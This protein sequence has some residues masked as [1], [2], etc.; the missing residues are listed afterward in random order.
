MLFLMLWQF[1][2]LIAQTPPVV[3]NSYRDS[4]IDAEE[5]TELI[6]LQDNTDLRGFTIRDN[7]TAGNWQPFVRFRNIDFWNHMR[8]GTIIVLFHRNPAPGSAFANQLNTGKSD[9]HIA[10]S[11]ENTEYFEYEEGGGS[12]PLASMSLAINGDMIQ[13]RNASGAHVHA[14]GHRADTTTNFNYWSALPKPKL[15]HRANLT[16]SNKEA[17]M[18]VPGANLDQYGFLSPINGLTYTQKGT[19]NL[20]GFPNQGTSGPNASF[21]RSLRQPDWINPTL[22]ASYN[23]QNHQVNLSW[24]SL[25]DSYPTDN[26]HGYMVLRS[27]TNSFQA[28]Q[29]GVIHGVGSQV[30]SATVVAL[31]NGSQNT[32]FT[33]N[34]SGNPIPCGGQYYYRV[35]AFRYGP[36]E[37]D[38]GSGPTRGR[39][40]NE[41]AFA[42]A[43]AAN[44]VPDASISIT[45]SSYNI[46]PG[47]QV[48][49]TASLINPGNNPTIT[50]YV[51]G[52]Q[53]QSGSSLTFS[54]TFTATAT[55]TATLQSS[56]PCAAPASAPP[57]QITVTAN[58]CN[59]GTILG[60]D[61]ICLNQ[62]ATY[63]SNG[64]TGGIWSVSNASIAQVNSQGVVTPLQPGTFTLYYTVD[65]SSCTGNPVASK[66]IFINPLP[67][68]GPDR[69]ICNTL[70][71]TLQGNAPIAGQ[72]F[73]SQVDGASIAVFSDNTYPNS[74]VTVSEY[75]SYMF[76]WNFDNCSPP[77]FVIITFLPL[78]Q[79]SV[80][81]APQTPQTCPGQSITFTATPSHLG[82]NNIFQWFHNG[83][84]VGSNN[85]GYTLL[86]PQ[87][88]DQ[89][90]V[91]YQTDAF[92][93]ASS[94]ASAGPVLV[95]VPPE[96]I[97]PS[98]AT[99]SH[100]NICSN[101]GAQITLTAFGGS[102]VELRWYEGSCGGNYIGS[103][104]DLDIPPPTQT[105]TYYARWETPGCG[106]SPC[107]SVTIEVAPPVA[108]TIN[109]AANETSICENE[110][111]T[112]VAEANHP[113]Q[114]PVYQWFKNGQPVGDNAPVYAAEAWQNGDAVQCQL[115]SDAFCASP[116]QVVSNT[117]V[118]N[119]SPL[120]IPA[121]R[122]GTSSTE[123][124]AGSL[125]HF[126][127]TEMAGGGA[128]PQF[129]WFVNGVAATG[130]TQNTFSIQA[131]GSFSVYCSLIPDVQCPA[132]PY[133]NSNVLQINV[134]QQVDPSISITTGQSQVCEG[135]PVS[136]EAAITGG[137]DNPAFLW[138][139]NGQPAGNQPTFTH[140][141]PANGDLVDCVLSSNAACASVPTV[142]SNSITLE[143]SPNVMVSAIIS[144]PQYTA[145]ICQGSSIEFMSSTSNGGI[146]PGYQ[147]YI[148]GNPAGNSPDLTYTFTQPGQYQVSLEF[149]SSLSCTFQNPVLSNILAVEVMPQVEA[150]V[151]VSASQ[152]AMCENTEVVLTAMPANAGQSPEYRWFRNGNL[153]QNTS[154]NHLVIS[155]LPGDIW[156]VEL[157]SSAQCVVN[158]PALSEPLGL[159]VDP[160]PMAP[161]I[162]TA[163]QTQICPNTTEPIV[164]T[165]Q[166]GAG[167]Q[168]VWFEGNCGE[169]P[170]G[171]A[172][173]LIINPPQQSANFFARYQS[174]LCPPSACAQIEITVSD[175][176]VPQVQI[177]GPDGAVCQGETAVFQVQ[178]QSGQGSLP[179]YD[180]LVNGVAQGINSHT[181]SYMPSN[182]DVVQCQMQS[183]EA[184][185]QPGTVLS[186]PLVVNVTQA[187]QPLVSI[188]PQSDT[189][190]FLQPIQIS[191]NFINS[192]NAPTY[193]WMINN[194]HLGQTG[195]ELNWF[196]PAPGNY[197][198]Y[199]LATSS[200]ACVASPTAFSQTVTITVLPNVVPTISISTPAN[201]L[202]SGQEAILE[203][204]AENPGQQPVFQWFVNG[205]PLS[206][207]N[208]PTLTYV[209]A[210]GDLVYCQM[211]SSAR[212]AE[213][214]VVT[215]N[216]ISFGVS[217]IVEPVAQVQTNSTQVCE[218]STAVFTAVFTG[219]GEQALIEWFV[220]ESPAG[221]GLTLSIIPQ[222]N[223]HI[224]YRLTSSLAC[225][226]PSV[227]Y[228]DTLSIHVNPLLTPE[229]NI[230]ASASQVCAGNAVSFSALA[231]NGGS[232]PQYNW[233]VNG[234]LQPG[235]G[236]ELIYTP[237]NMDVVHCEM[238]SSEQCLSQPSATSPELVMVVEPVFEPAISIE[239][240]QTT[241][242]EG[243]EVIITALVNQAGLADVY[244]WFVDGQITGENSP[245]LTITA[246]GTQQIRCVLTSSVN[247]ALPLQV[248]SEVLWVE[249]LPVLVPQIS[250]SAQQQEV[251]QGTT[252]NFESTIQHG[253]NNPVYSWSVNG[254]LLGNQATF[255]YQPADEDQVQCV[256]LSDYACASP[257]QTASEIVLMHVSENLDLHL[258]K[259]NAG[260]NG[261]EGAIA[262]TGIQGKPP[263]KYRI[264]NHTEWQES[265]NFTAVLPGSYVVRI[266]DIYGCQA[267]QEVVIE[268]ETG[269]VITDVM[270][271]PASNGFNN[272]SV[273]IQASGAEPLSYSVNEID[274]QSSPIF[275]NL[276]QGGLTLYVRDANGC[277]TSQTIDIESLPVNISA[278]QAS[279]CKGNTLPVPVSTDGF[280]GVTR[281]MLEMKYDDKLLQFNGPSQ[282]HTVFASANTTITNFQ[283]GFR[284][285]I[286]NSNGIHMPGGGTMMYLNFVALA[287]GSSIL[288]W[289]AVSAIQTQHQAVAPANFLNGQATIW[290]APEITMPD[291]Y[292]QCL[293][294]PLEIKPSIE[295]DYTLLNWTIPG[296]G[297]SQSAYLSFGQTLWN[298][299]GNYQL[300][301]INNFGCETT[302][303]TT[304]IVLPCEAELPVPN[305]FRPDSPIVEN[306][307]FKPYFGQAV[308]LS[309]H[310]KIFNRWGA[311]VFETSDHNQGW[312]GRYNGQAAPAGTYIW[313]IQYSA[314]GLDGPFES[315]K[316]GTLTLL[317]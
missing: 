192:G 8:R 182:N 214:V 306:Q 278:G 247:C 200:L 193:Q 198:I 77:D 97:A 152:T 181:F 31:I 89:V 151:Q 10:L 134:T 72:A 70:S 285:L 219:G 262:A 255:S 153:F 224:Y 79:L 51:D 240:T 290:P 236:P 287:A 273:H 48:T 92:C 38:Q 1:V 316:K 302:A 309:Y 138:R 312:D 2:P 44:P 30:G 308:P 277:I 259:T 233:F 176:I 179:T 54:W 157:I 113:G 83:Q 284:I 245:Q 128:N 288:K 141:N 3:I 41:T 26:V 114:N 108:P 297:N 204:A 246:V 45:A 15:N 239:T 230:Q 102:G 188:S 173:P 112:F 55:V 101:F 76:S 267:T 294:K 13:I 146:A 228:S 251:C 87:D 73:W 174:G 18:V 264:D 42:A 275:S 24:N 34:L 266:E 310:L 143:V 315:T 155:A 276:P 268:T 158:S 231:V 177:S 221:S 203:A 145:P 292:R 123:V 258:E 150:S 163:S 210:D 243:D 172:N 115:I 88:G 286:E 131:S 11:L 164:L 270:Q 217:S 47:T 32:T 183:S 119:V 162:I 60:Q 81:V 28:P 53:R 27:A 111:V 17:V 68:A 142:V 169:N 159:E 167:Q 20:P 14:L 253:G 56:L 189:V 296:G 63:E 252:V 256:L 110:T 218:Q 91:Q 242:C 299:E 16:S 57:V 175:L 132:V 196:A 136:F 271:V 121:I 100:T 107:Q 46:L 49:F 58:P 12:M 130:A 133:E 263:Y 98:F 7:S 161:E 39:A 257:P 235:N 29:D 19:K 40:Y 103:G 117:I 104:T 303:S 166:G 272:A 116:N 94:N 43:S 106:E 291:T 37:I 84:L 64:T 211:V 21:W 61:V 208:N 120:I 282:I 311:M 234:N 199:L 4:N 86:N 156:Q 248:S 194:N 289:E 187:V 260:C 137:G 274:W 35:Y 202:C 122:I 140:H 25:T 237:E 135:T 295:G 281:L 126:T 269:P 36:D 109:I 222:H 197:Q 301:A 293:G 50:W 191:S 254:Q 238:V 178:S 305:A 249:A 184:C 65:N 66:Q 206:G 125:V 160:M 6:V 279:G 261:S 149:S 99:A 5:W 304:L 307:T 180:W 209:P 265:G 154:V 129:Q 23:A 215:S 313:V 127:I 147:W 124:C 52:I 118:L 186:E 93:L 223:D 212:C 185:A 227:V 232:T 226:Q 96:A 71:T 241:Y 59:P 9:G 82:S 229:V 75:G 67:Y 90:G 283:G 317:R 168:L 314:M 225:A 213:P 190:C 33:D 280:A 205:S 148:N 201:Q 105:T 250:I 139:V 220:N 244:Q 195:P 170:V 216:S 62:T 95:T 144:S 85:P 171:N 80:S 300:T 74:T 298:H 69:Q 207:A 78:Q 165:A 22:T